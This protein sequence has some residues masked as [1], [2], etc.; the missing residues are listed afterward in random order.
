MI[1][2]DTADEII[3]IKQEDSMTMTGDD[4]EI[5]VHP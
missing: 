2:K 3:G 4:N 1:N 5:V